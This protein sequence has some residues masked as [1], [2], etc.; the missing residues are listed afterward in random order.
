M[1][2][3]LIASLDL[4]LSH[5]TKLNRLQKDGSMVDEMH[6]SQFSSLKPQLLQ[7]SL[8]VATDSTMMT[9]PSH[10]AFVTCPLPEQAS[11]T[12]ALRIDSCSASLSWK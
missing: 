3:A 9:N 4:L 1:F 12:T 7:F 2:Q 8:A 6:R 5:I 11:L 10:W